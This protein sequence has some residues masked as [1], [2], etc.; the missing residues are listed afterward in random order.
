MRTAVVILNWN[1]RDYLE[2]FLPPLLDSLRGLDAGVVVADN[3]S[4]DGS[5][6]LLARR[7]PNVRTI[8]FD[9]NYGFTGGYNRAFAELLGDSPIKSA[10]DEA[11]RASASCRAEQKLVFRDTSRNE[12]TQGVRGERPPVIESGRPQGE[13]KP[14]YLVLLNSDIEVQGGWLEPLVGWMDAH[15]DYAACGPRLHAL[16][17]DGKEYRRTDRFEYAGAAGGYLDRYGFPFC[18]G[19]V[20]SR[21]EQDN[22]QY[23]RPADVLWATGAC[24]LVRVSAW[25]ELGGLDERFFAHMEEIDWCWRAWLAGWRVG[26][27]PQSCVWHLGGGTLAPSSPLKLKLNY[28][29]GLLLLENN[30]PAT[31]GPARARRRICIR[32]ILDSCAAI[33]Y[34]LSGKAD[35]ARAVRDAH[36]EY[37]QLRGTPGTKSA[38]SVPGSP[39]NTIPGT[40]AGPGVPGKS[41]AGLWNVRILLQAAL[42]GEKIF[43]YVRR[44]EDSH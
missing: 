31:L 39:Q 35:C 37:R 36:R 18:R 13:G 19:R 9:E 17:P 32:K 4:T 25:H 29:N 12:V 23:D 42:R 6:E 24:L 5:R 27:V 28:R 2:R 22:G 33:V 15:P 34:L 43:K 8:L 41:V 16:E 21:T 30:L 20:L 40:K 1:T 38:P 10:N 14:E 3:A 11:C 26:V 44:Y 7:F